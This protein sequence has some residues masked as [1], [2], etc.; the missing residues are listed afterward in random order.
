MK[1]FFCSWI[2]TTRHTSAQC[3]KKAPDPHPKKVFLDYTLE[4][5]DRSKLR[6]KSD[7]DVAMLFRQVMWIFMQ[8]IGY[9]YTRRRNGENVTTTALKA[10]MAKMLNWLQ[11]GVVISEEEV[12]D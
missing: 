2:F 8:S 6:V 3:Q 5:I 12:H 9:Y 11:Y 7:E 10:R 1:M 4:H